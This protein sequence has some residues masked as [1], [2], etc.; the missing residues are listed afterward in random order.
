MFIKFGVTKVKNYCF[1]SLT[2]DEEDFEDRRDELNELVL[3]KGNLEI[4]RFFNLDNQVYE[5]GSL[6]RKT[7]E[8]LGLVASLVMRCDDCIEYHLRRCSE[9]DV[10][11]EELIE[12]LSI[13]LVVGGSVTI[14][15]LRET[16]ET[17]YDMKEEG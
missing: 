15:H 12:T 9:E 8:L 5:D 4:K 14:P 6:P 11:D 16:F 10:S 2:M 1:T 13:G 3:E 17:W 7:K